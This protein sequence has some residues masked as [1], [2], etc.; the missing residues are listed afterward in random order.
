MLPSLP[1]FRSQNSFIGHNLA[2]L[3]R[4]VLK[5]NCELLWKS[6]WWGVKWIMPVNKPKEHVSEFTLQPA[7]ISSLQTWGFFKSHAQKGHFS[8]LHLKP[9]DN[10]DDVLSDVP[11]NSRQ[12]F[13]FGFVIKFSRVQVCTMYLS[14][15]DQKWLWVSLWGLPISDLILLTISGQIFRLFSHKI[16]LDYLLIK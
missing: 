4:P 10:S 5:S 11:C 14:T 7:L 12:H 9:T 8:C 15:W 3:K 1:H 13:S 2:Q 6:S 16:V